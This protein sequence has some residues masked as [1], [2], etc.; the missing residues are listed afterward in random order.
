MTMPGRTKKRKERLQTVK[1]LAE[2]C[3]HIF[4]APTIN[5]LF[6]ALSFHACQAIRKKVKKSSNFKNKRRLPQNGPQ[7]R[8]LKLFFNK[9]GLAL[10]DLFLT[11]NFYVGDMIRV[12]REYL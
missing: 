11:G 10:T 8:R 12:L 6:P 7:A 4:P 5:E 3:A 1:D 2:V 9:Y